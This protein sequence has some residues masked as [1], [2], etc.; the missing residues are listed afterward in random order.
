[1]ALTANK[2]YRMAAVAPD[3]ITRMP[4][5][6]AA[7]VFQ[8]SLL[9]LSANRARALVAGD[10]FLGVC[11]SDADNTGGAAGAI[12]VDVV[13]RG[14]IVGATVTGAAATSLNAVVYASDD[15]TLTLTASTN[16]K[17]G[18]VCRV[19][20]NLTCDIQFAASAFDVDT[21]SGA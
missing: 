18:F 1:M 12:D 15:G 21:V 2:P 17:I 19:N 9:G 16:T 10:T 4:L 6:A 11:R 20:A 8:G 14:Q 3:A 5:I 13:Q 7:R